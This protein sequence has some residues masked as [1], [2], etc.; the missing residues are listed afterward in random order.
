MISLSGH[1][2]SLGGIN[3]AVEDIIGNCRELNIPVVYGLSRRKL[4]Y[5]LRKKHKVG[6]LGIFSYDGAEVDIF[7][8]CHC[9]H[10]NSGTLSLPFV[11]VVLFRF[12]TSR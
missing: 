2:I 12:G 8:S 3:S 7:G 11:V 6:C 4:A 10:S 9:C 5:L 1:V